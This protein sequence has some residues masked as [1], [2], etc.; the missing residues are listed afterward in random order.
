MK[1]KCERCG[2]FGNCE[3]RA[4]PEDEAYLGDDTK[5]WICDECYKHSLKSLRK[6]L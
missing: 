3:Y 2:D 5:Y 4:Y 6:E 1:R